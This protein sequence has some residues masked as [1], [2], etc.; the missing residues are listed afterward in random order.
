VEH[1]VHDA[2]RPAVYLAVNR[3]VNSVVFMAV[4]EICSAV[5]RQTR[6]W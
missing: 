2:V 4:S 3:A 6:S 1:S 5:D